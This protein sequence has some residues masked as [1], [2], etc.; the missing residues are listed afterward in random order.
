MLEINKVHNMDCMD[1][2]EQIAPVDAII[3]DPPYMINTK[4]DGMGKLNPWADYCNGAYWYTEW[5]KK[6][7][8]KLKPTGCMWVFLNWRSMVTYQKAACD[9]SW[10]I[11]SLL[12]WDKGTIGPGMKGLR[13]SYEMVA[14]LAGAEFSIKDRSIPDIRL[15][16][17]STTKPNGHPAE[18]P[19]KLIEWLI[20]I[21]T[22]EGATV[23]DPFMGSG[24][25]AEAAAATS[26]NFIGSE[27]DARWCNYGNDRYAAHKSQT[28][29]FG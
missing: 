26:R 27:I 1:F 9:A 20:S 11:E 16:K 14:L 15:E 25:T 18:K 21:S 10:A 13:P 7:R 17:W 24:T 5:F 28:S 19:V 23:C 2:L 6:A 3:T 8:R 22:P 29:L 12:I 4:S